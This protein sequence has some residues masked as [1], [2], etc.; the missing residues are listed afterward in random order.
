[1]NKF[2]EEL[3]S[4]MKKYDIKSITALSDGF[5]I[6]SEYPYEMT[7]AIIQGYN[8][9]KTQV[10]NKFF[11]DYNFEETFEAENEQLNLIKKIAEQDIQKYTAEIEELKKKVGFAERHNRELK[12]EIE[13]LRNT[14]SVH[15]KIIEK[16]LN[17]S[18]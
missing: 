12:A 3:V 7:N 10:R 8:D 11:E 18:C 17:E 13:R 6:S 2:F 4:L 5:L 1:M 15:E 9:N 16:L 14:I